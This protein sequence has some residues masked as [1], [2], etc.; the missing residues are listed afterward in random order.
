[1]KIAMLD[2]VLAKTGHYKEF[3]KYILDLLDT[4]ENE[5]LL[6]DISST[7]GEWYTSCHPQNA[8][9]TIVN[10]AEQHDKRKRVS[11]PLL[12]IISSIS[13]LKSERRWY[14][15]IIEKIAVW[16]P[17]L[18]LL[19]GQPGNG[20]FK[21]KRIGMPVAIIF[22]SI[23][24]I[25]GSRSV[26]SQ[27][28]SLKL[29]SE[30]R[31]TNSFLTS[32]DAAVILLEDYSEAQ[33]ASLGYRTA[34]IPAY[35]Y[36]DCKIELPA[37]AKR[38]EYFLVSSVGTI[39]RGKNIDFVLDVIQKYKPEFFVYRIAGNPRGTYGEEVVRIF[40]KVDSNWVISNFGYL[41]D[42]QYLQEICSAD[43][44]LIPYERSRVGQSSGVMFDS[45][46]CDTPIIAAN[47]E[48]FR[49]YIEKYNIGLLYKENDGEDL[50]K[51]IRTA[52]E[53][54]KESF[55]EAIHA[56]REENDI[57]RWRAKFSLELSSYVHEWK[58]SH[59]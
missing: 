37:V 44:T 41:S 47:I 48:P 3:N 10:V 5:I 26:K 31:L 59:L 32:A 22:H 4:S 17:D 43:F 35:A 21:L 53:R 25:V 16:N 56:F 7:F 29:E 34:R 33:I 40:E 39:N 57:G 14:A 30:R 38:T 11:N 55:R 49:S 19:T 9:L 12:D 50:L 58:S 45:M 6:A 15:S 13:N 8:I 52:R 28:I 42:E 27:L 20:F 24:K 46:K 36:C 18:I 54:G 51:V 23:R 2:P 1:M